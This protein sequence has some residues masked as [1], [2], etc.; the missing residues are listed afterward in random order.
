MSEGTREDV[1][2][3]RRPGGGAGTMSD[4]TSRRF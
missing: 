1:A 2:A 4:S 3:G